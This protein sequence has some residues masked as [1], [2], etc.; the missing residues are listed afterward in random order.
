MGLKPQDYKVTAEF[1]RVDGK[2]T[3]IM[4]Q[5]DIFGPIGEKVQNVPSRV[6]NVNVIGTSGACS[7]KLVMAQDAH[8][9]FR[10]TT[11]PR[12]RPPQDRR[13]S[14]GGLSLITAAL[15]HTGRG[16]FAFPEPMSPSRGGVP[17]GGWGRR[18]TLSP[19]P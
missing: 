6:C 15:F 11:R 3:N 16:Q 17:A 2:K 13:S 1:K 14:S 7:V 12:S 8:V 4:A 9:L 10:P 19:F 18:F 5:V